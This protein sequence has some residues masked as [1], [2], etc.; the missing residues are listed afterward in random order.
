EARAAAAAG[1][2]LVGGPEPAALVL[3]RLPTAL[4]ALEDLAEQVA[5]TA[6]DGVRLVLGG[7]VKHMTRSQNEVL[8]DH[9]AEVSASL[10]RQKS[11]VLHASGPLRT[12]TPRWPRERVLDHPALGAPLTVRSHGRVFAEGRLDAGTRLLLAAM[13]RAELPTGDALD[14]G[15]GSGVV[16]AWLARRGR[17]TRAVDVSAAAV[18]STA[19]TAVANGLTVEVTQAVGLESVPERSLDLLVSNPPF[20]VGAAKDS[21]PTLELIDSAASRLRPGG[22]LWLVWNAHLPYLPRLR[23]AVGPTEVVSRDR[24]YLVTR[25]RLR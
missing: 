13:D 9:F 7:R 5:A 2:E 11:R 10:G 15:S 6:P 18:A 21:T 22:E 4:S 19:A 16:A 8:A 25:S 1:A 20:H 12:A 23:Q 24:S 17:T 14:W 3:G